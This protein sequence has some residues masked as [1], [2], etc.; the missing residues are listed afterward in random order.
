MQR[1]EV[2]PAVT[3]I[4]TDL[5]KSVEIRHEPELCGGF[6]ALAKKGTFRFTSYQTTE[7]E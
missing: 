6:A 1:E 3:S 4:Q 7:K 5:S 2:D